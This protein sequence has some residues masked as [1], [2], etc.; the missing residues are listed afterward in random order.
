MV[1]GELKSVFSLE[2]VLQG[3]N[4]KAAC[5]EVWLAVEVTGRGGRVRYQPPAKVFL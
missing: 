4:R 2:L 1:V 5:D 3:V